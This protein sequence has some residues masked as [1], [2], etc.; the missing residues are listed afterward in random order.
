MFIHRPNKKTR[1]FML[2][3]ADLHS[4]PH[5]PSNAHPSSPAKLLHVA[6]C[7]S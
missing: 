4:N 6:Y 5:G 2:Q 3:G 7:R 1:Q